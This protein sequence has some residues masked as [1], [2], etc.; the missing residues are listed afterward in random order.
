[1]AA[2]N[3]QTAEVVRIIL[4]FFSYMEVYPKTGKSTDIS[5]QEL[6]IDNYNLYLSHVEENSRG[7]AI[8]VKDT[9][10]STLNLELT[11]HSFNENVLVNIQ[12]KEKETFLIGG[13][14]RSPQSSTENNDLLLDLLE[15]VKREK[16][17][18]L[19]ILGDFNLPEINWELWTTN[20]GENHLSYKFLECLMYP[21]QLDHTTFTPDS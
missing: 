14:Y 6:Q 15:K 19:L 5:E 3:K 13:V 18:N 8:Y 10:S 17:S 21:N 16:F 4:L 9:V 1:M 7:V 12:L 2:N 11:N 20:R